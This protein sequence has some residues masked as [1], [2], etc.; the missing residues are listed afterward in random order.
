MKDKYQEFNL[1]TDQLEESFRQVQEAKIEMEKT[2]DSILQSIATRHENF[3][4]EL[5][6]SLERINKTQESTSRNSEEIDELL[7]AL[8]S[9]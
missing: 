7:K 8:E 1:M 9:I 6:E 4:K 5:A 2:R 3:E